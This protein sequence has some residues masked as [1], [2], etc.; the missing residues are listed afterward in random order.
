MQTST[1]QSITFLYSSK[2]K[3]QLSEIKFSFP[4]VTW[5]RKQRK[6]QEYMHL[7]TTHTHYIQYTVIMQYK[8]SFCLLKLTF[9]V[10][11]WGRFDGDEKLEKEKPDFKLKEILYNFRHFPSFLSLLEDS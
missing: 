11:G 7:N 1:S 6:L 10:S 9:A 8:F 4:G 5:L 2:L 3:K